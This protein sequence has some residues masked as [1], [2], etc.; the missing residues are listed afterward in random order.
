VWPISLHQPLP[1]LPVPLL[2]PD[3]DVPLDLGQ[4]LRT[5]HERARYDLRIDYSAPPDPPLSDADAAWAAT[6][7]ERSL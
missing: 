1:A 4:A 5:A 7:L 3:P 2:R 6:L